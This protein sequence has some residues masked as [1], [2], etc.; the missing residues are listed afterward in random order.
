MC[1]SNVKFHEK[2][3]YIIWWLLIQSL[4]LGSSPIRWPVMI[5]PTQE[6]CCN[7]LPAGINRRS[8][9]THSLLILVNVKQEFFTKTGIHNNIHSF[10]T[11]VTNMP[12]L[13]KYSANYQFLFECPLKL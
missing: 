3:K 6:P 11:K 1:N 2:T 9:A 12:D 7:D 5:L 8:R 10:Y 4:H 13:M